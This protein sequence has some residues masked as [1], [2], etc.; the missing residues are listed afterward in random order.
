MAGEYNALPE[1][2]KIIDDDEVLE[3]RQIAEMLHKSEE[4]VRRWCRKG[5]LLNI[6]PTGHYKIYGKDL[7]EFFLMKFRENT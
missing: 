6:S 5:Q 3:P 2:I 4:T 1:L 7:K